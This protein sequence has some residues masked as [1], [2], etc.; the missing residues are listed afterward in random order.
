MNRIKIATYVIAF[1]ACSM[2]VAALAPVTIETAW[3]H[4]TFSISTTG[5]TSATFDIGGFGSQGYARSGDTYTENGVDGTTLGTV[6][7]VTTNTTNVVG[8]S[9]SALTVGGAGSLQISQTIKTPERRGS[10]GF[11]IQS[12]TSIPSFT[13][14]FPGAYTLTAPQ[15]STS[16]TISLRD[17]VSVSDTFTAQVSN[18]RFIFTSLTAAATLYFSTSFG[19]PRAQ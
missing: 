17:S 14:P 11:G 19:S 7:S 13:S 10:L 16:S 4:K 9:W 6:V 8:F 3:N 15:I 2:P 1:L 18:P 12:S 5:V